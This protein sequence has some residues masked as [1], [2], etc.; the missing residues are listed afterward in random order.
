MA[1]ERA[2]V[3]GL[4][5]LEALQVTFYAVGN[6]RASCCLCAEEFYGAG[7]DPAESRRVRGKLWRFW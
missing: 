3:Y 4:L 5:R 1:R 7:F 6:W 2:M